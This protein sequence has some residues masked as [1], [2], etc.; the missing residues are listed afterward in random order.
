MK[1]ETPKIPT[2]NKAYKLL[3]ERRIAEFNSLHEQGLLNTDFSG[4]SFRGID[5]RGMDANGLD[6]SN[7]R[8]RQSDLR[9]I[10]FT[11]TK[12]EGASFYGAKISGTYFPK[13]FSANELL[14]SVTQGTRVRTGK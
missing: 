10:N 4:L 12:L 6:F 3:R 1:D 5:L 8:F 13:E 7:C 14:L 11:N 2:D 9:G